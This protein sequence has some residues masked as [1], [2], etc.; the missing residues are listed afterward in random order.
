[1]S[2]IYGLVPL[3]I[4]QVFFDIRWNRHGTDVVQAG[5]KYTIALEPDIITVPVC[6]SICSITVPV[7]ALLN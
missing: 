2:G 3:I 4:V 7:T 5:F 6:V 1:M